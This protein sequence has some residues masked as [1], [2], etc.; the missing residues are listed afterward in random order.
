[1]RDKIIKITVEVQEIINS[2][3]VGDA[4]AEYFW[5]EFNQ[6]PLHEQRARVEQL[7]SQE[8]ENFSENNAPLYLALMKH[9]DPEIRKAAVGAMWFYPE[10]EYIETILR[11]CKTDPDDEVRGKAASVLGRYIYEGWIL[12]E[13]DPH[14][15]R[16]LIEELLRIAEDVHESITVRRFS[17]ESLGF[18]YDDPRVLN[19]IENA[20]FS[21]EEDMRLSAIFA[22]GRNGNERWISYL[23]D[24]LHD[25]NKNLRLEAICACGEAQIQ[26][27]FS[28]LKALC[29]ESDKEVRLE[30]I[31]ALGKL[32]IQ[33]ALQ[34]LCLCTQDKDEDIRTMA[35]EAIEELSLASL[36]DQLEFTEISEEGLFIPIQEFFAE[37]LTDTEQEE[38]LFETGREEGDEEEGFVGDFPA[39]AEWDTFGEEF[40]EEFLEEF[41]EDFDEDDS[42]DDDD[43]KRF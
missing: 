42:D 21:P 30:A 15:M 8:E 5:D 26:E 2:T 17:M 33:P 3:G 29:F 6:L 1:M 4:M 40:D 9:P 41:E 25:P 28:E 37:F 43:E 32:G 16:Y 18:V 7:V 20:Y 12:E 23:L 34:T 22:M 39:E 35:Q 24:S 19:L 10:E 27:S 13:F 31:W 11:L 14:L 38:D 36:E